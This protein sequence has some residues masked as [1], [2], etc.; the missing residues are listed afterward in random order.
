MRT[1]WHEHLTEQQVIRLADLPVAAS[2]IVMCQ[3][4]PVVRCAGRLRRAQPYLLPAAADVVGGTAPGRDSRSANS[5]RNGQVCS[6]TSNGR[7]AL[8]AGPGLGADS[9]QPIIAEVGAQA[10]RSGCG[11]LCL[12]TASPRV[13]FC[14]ARFECFPNRRAN[15]I[16]K[17][18]ER[19]RTAP[20][21]ANRHSSVAQ[22]QS[23]RLLTGGL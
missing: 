8:G 19:T 12:S 9:A 5:T 16:I 1:S 23:I 13:T 14:M 6:A 22:W 4:S 7:R 21:A 3:A 15:A 17:F 2:P 20:F 10:A 18:E 11:L